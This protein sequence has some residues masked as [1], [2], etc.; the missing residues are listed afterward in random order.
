MTMG[1][2]VSVL[3]HFDLLAVRRSLPV[4]YTWWLANLV[5]G[6]LAVACRAWMDGPQAWVLAVITQAVVPELLEKLAPPQTTPTTVLYLIGRSVSGQFPT[7]FSSAVSGSP[8]PRVDLVVSTA[9]AGAWIA[10]GAIAA[11]RGFH[12]GR[13][14]FAS[15]PWPS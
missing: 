13:G 8:H 3:G 9:Y 10:I 7:L 15:R 11:S 5:L 1:A 2:A 4:V 12:R 14:D 6:T